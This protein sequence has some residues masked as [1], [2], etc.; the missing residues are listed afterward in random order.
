[1]PVISPLQ[2]AWRE[3]RRDFFPRFDR[4]GNWRVTSGHFTTVIGEMGY[5]DDKTRRILVAPTLAASGGDQLRA[6]LIH[7]VIHAVLQ[8]ASHGARFKRR[9]LAAQTRAL[10]LGRHTL[11]AALK[12]HA[13]AYENTERVTAESVYASMRD[14]VDQ[15]RPSNFLE[16]RRILAGEFPLFFLRRCRPLEREYRARMRFW[17]GNESK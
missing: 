10:V 1:M 6:T 5:C 12:Q 16:A 8:D 3:I 13:I 7:E 9:L 15:L 2:N 14:L 11:A 4:R 17:L